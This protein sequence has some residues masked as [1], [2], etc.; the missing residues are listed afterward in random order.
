MPVLAHVNCKT[1]ELSLN[2]IYATVRHTRSSFPKLR[3]SLVIIAQPFQQASQPWATIPHS[4]THSFTPPPL[5]NG[6]PFPGRSSNCFNTALAISLPDTPITGLYVLEGG[7]PGRLSFDVFYFWMNKRGVITR[8]QQPRLTC[9][10]GNPTANVFVTA[11]AICS[12]RGQ[13]ESTK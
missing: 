9:P 10:S 5:C 2:D 6:F 7:G 8:G 12:I 1:Q 13:Y 3:V 4:G 11:T